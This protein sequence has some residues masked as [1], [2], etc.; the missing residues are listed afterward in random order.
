[1]RDTV[2]RTTWTRGRLPAHT[3][4]WLPTCTTQR[5]PAPAETRAIA[6]AADRCSAGQLLPGLFFALAVAAVLLLGAPAA[7]GQELSGIPAAF[8]DVGIGAGEMGMG[9]AVTGS[10]AGASA[11][12]WN[13]A[14]LG[15][16]EHDRGVFIAYCDQMG[17]VP[18]SAG[19]ALYTLGDYALGLGVLYSGDEVLSETTVLLGASRGLRVLPWD[20]D[21]EADLGLAVRT[22]WAS[23][24]NNQSAGEQVTGSALG[25]GLDLGARIPLGGSTTL[26]LAA[27]DMVNMLNWDSSAAGSY[28]ENVPAT[29]SAGVAIRPHDGLLVELD[30]DKTIGGD[31]DDVIRAGAELGLFGVAHLR[32]GYITRLPE[33][34]PDEYSVG[35]GA[36]FPAGS[37][38][39]TLDAAYLFGHLDNTLRFS[40][41]VAL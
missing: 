28:G 16:A 4:Q 13:P 30:L 7:S 39:M 15:R 3:T 9:G 26:G 31:A 18:Y 29:V 41:G 33:G 11:I 36:T 21:R 40:L 2:R 32:G 19:S 23:Y 20:P 6:V 12:F 8:V 22:R 25:V 35:A 37:T 38:S 1:M 17:L 34:D 14:G 27:R 24:G 10:V 5:P